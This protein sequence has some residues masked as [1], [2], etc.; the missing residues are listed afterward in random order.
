MAIA[1][2]K[3]VLVRY[4]QE[5]WHESLVTW[6]VD[7]AEHVVCT[8]DFDFYVE[9]LDLGNQDLTGIRYYGPGGTL[10]V[11]VAAADVYGFQAFTEREVY[12]VVVEGQRLAT[13]ERLARGLGP[14]TERLGPPLAPGGP[15]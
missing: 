5:V 12:E 14:A 10:P 13:A 2:G 7:L 9:R 6:H 3:V 1:T 15:R 8:P 11:G 4:D